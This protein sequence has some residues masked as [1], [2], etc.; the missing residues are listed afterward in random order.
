MKE[1]YV[2]TIKADNRPGLLH[3][4][5]GMINRRLIDIESLNAARTDINDIVL[6]SIELSISEKALTPLVLKLKN[7]I[8][9]F[10]VEAVKTERA[11][12]IR[13]AFFKMNKTFLATPAAEIIRRHQMQISNIYPDAILLAKSGSEAEI[14]S[15]Y[16][17][18]EGPHLLGYSQTGI[19]VDSKLIDNNDEWRISRLAA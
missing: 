17:Q 8:E 7:I 15:L 18:L 5:T 11:V 19:I 13:S 10:S 1:Q 3:L 4:V 16:N 6:V 14:R 9:V 12:A 2:I